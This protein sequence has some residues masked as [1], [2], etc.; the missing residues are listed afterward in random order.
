MAGAESDV[1]PGVHDRID[2]VCLRVRRH[3]RV[4][5]RR[6]DG[7]LTEDRSAAVADPPPADQQA[8]SIGREVTQALM[9]LPA[10]GPGRPTPV[11]LE[12][13]DRFGAANLLPRFV[14]ADLMLV[15]RV[16]DANWEVVRGLLDL[17]PLHSVG[18]VGGGLRLQD[19][20]GVEQPLPT[21]P[22]LPTAG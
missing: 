4:M 12:W 1:E 11:R 6:G 15:G 2:L 19:D 8:L 5:W 18:I 7:S 16:D 17:V 20:G 13:V 21:L 22:T 10:P 3:R 9:R 14:A